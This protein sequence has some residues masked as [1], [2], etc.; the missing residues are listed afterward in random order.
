MSFNFTPLVTFLRSTL[1]DFHTFRRS[2]IFG[3]IAEEAPTKVLN[4]YVDFTDVFSLGLASKL[5]KH[6]GINDY[7][8]E[9][10]N[11]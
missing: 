1:L 11:G 6:T 4:E 8:I 3:L 10:V 7:A 2:Q 5:P 9:P